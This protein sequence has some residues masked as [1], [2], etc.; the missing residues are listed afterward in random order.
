MSV[1]EG[2]FKRVGY[3]AYRLGWP[4]LSI[5][6]SFVE[7]IIHLPGKRFVLGEFAG[8]W[9]GNA[10]LGLLVAAGTGLA[11]GTMV[12]AD[13][14]ETRRANRIAIGTLAIGMLTLIL[15]ETIPG[16]GPG[17]KTMLDMLAPVF[18]AGGAI[19]IGGLLVESGMLIANRNRGV[20]TGN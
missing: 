16:F 18:A 1:P 20:R 10:T 6:S 2:G 3:Y 17:F 12:V 7:Q 19:S 9:M 14:G 13:H 8:Y 5:G 4:V 11:W 15:H